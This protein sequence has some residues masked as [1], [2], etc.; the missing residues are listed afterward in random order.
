MHA[1]R[2]DMLHAATSMR[3]GALP[4][5]TGM[6]IWPERVC[7]SVHLCLQDPNTQLVFQGTVGAVRMRFY[8]TRCGAASLE[9]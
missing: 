7:R 2:S 6:T 1:L 8:P 3:E 4:K 9:H 5:E